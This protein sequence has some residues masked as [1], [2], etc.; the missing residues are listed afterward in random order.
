MENYDVWNHCFAQLTEENARDNSPYQRF[1]SQFR[2]LFIS[3]KTYVTKLVQKGLFIPRLTPRKDSTH[4]DRFQRWLC[5]V[6]FNQE[7]WIKFIE[8]YGKHS[9]I[10]IYCYEMLSS[11]RPEYFQNVFLSAIQNGAKR[12]RSADGIDEIEEPAKKKT[13]PK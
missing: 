12:L 2:T 6:E 5:G 8:N 13:P 7:H 4:K 1:I 3:A 10:L 11:H 9:K